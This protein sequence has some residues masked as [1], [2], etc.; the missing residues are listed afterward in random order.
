MTRVT[1]GLL[2]FLHP[3]ECVSNKL[4]G[5][6]TSAPGRL[7]RRPFDG[8]SVAIFG[9]HT[10]GQPG[11]CGAFT[12]RP[13][14]QW[15][16][17]V[18]DPAHAFGKGAVKL[19][20]RKGYYVFLDQ[21]SQLNGGFRSRRRFAPGGGISTR[22]LSGNDALFAPAVWPVYRG[23]SLALGQVRFFDSN[24][25]INVLVSVGTRFELHV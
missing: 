24:F 21:F 1:I 8:L 3:P 17:V 25:C 16:R 14:P 12:E 15:C 4:V 9:V 13:F 7:V 6:K 22:T 5:G 18:T 10:F 19:R 20:L 11:S 23:G 2:L